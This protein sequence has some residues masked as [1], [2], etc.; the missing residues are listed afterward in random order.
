MDPSLATHT[1]TRFD[2]HETEPIIVEPIDK[3]GSDRKF[4]RIRLAPG[5][6]VILVKY[7]TN[8]EENLRYAQIAF[9]LERLGVRVPQIY[10]H[11]KAEG[12]LW[13]EDLGDRDLWS[14][15]SEA[16]DVRRKLYESA[17]NEVHILHREGIHRLAAFGISVEKEFDTQLYLWEQRYFFE[18]CAHRYFQQPHEHLVPWL[19]HPVLLSAAEN[20]AARDR[21]LVHRDFQS[22]NI[23]IREGAAALIDFQGLR[24][25]LAAYDLA[26]LLYDPYVDLSEQ[27]RGELVGYYLEGMGS[28]E[29]DFLFVLRLCA[30]QRLMQA[31]GAYGFLGLERGKSEFLKYIPRALESLAVVTSELPNLGDFSDWLRNLHTAK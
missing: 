6:S 20:L 23:I 17:L 30:M 21:V 28:Q 12:L 7:G 9:F 29:D 1:R 25:G 24:P 5:Q 11:D 31:L 3:G 2:L 16:W 4:Y 14:F 26:S 22:Q 8:R 15:Q 13:M 19:Q 18:N 10:Y 27:Q